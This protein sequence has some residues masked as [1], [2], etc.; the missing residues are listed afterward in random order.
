MAPRDGT[1]LK[2]ESGQTPPPPPPPKNDTWIPEWYQ[3]FYA[4]TP[5][6]R[7]AE[8][9]SPGSVPFSPVGQPTEPSYGISALGGGALG[10]G[11]FLEKQALNAGDAVTRFLTSQ[12]Q[13][14]WGKGLGNLAYDNVSRPTPLLPNGGALAAGLEMQEAGMDTGG[15]P[16]AS[17]GGQYKPNFEEYMASM[18]IGAGSGGGAARPDFS[19]YRAALTD[20][21]QQI[22]AQIQAMYNA[23]GE[24]AGANVG[25]IQDIYG[26]ASE[27][28]GDVYGSAIGNVG[29][30]YGSAQ[31]QAADQLARLG[32]EAA[33]PAVINP[34]ALSQAEAISQLEQGQAGG[35]AATERFGSAASGF[36]SQMAQ[37]AQQQ[38]TEMNAAILASLQNRLMDSLAAEQQGGGGGGGGGMS[39]RD[40]LALREAYNRDVLGQMPLEEREFALR[41]AQALADPVLSRSQRN[42]DLFLELTLPQDGQKPLMTDIE[43]EDYIRALES[44]GY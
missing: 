33:A 26:G 24:E 31:Q 13:A 18:G 43:A 20:Q 4:G 11:R 3:R 8:A 37:V 27:G 14:G 35:Q 28:I 29:D 25:R 19:A 38:G 9:Q 32:I 12:P 39:V 16:F 15:V 36:G 30:A 17:A 5:G 7:T 6:G 10:V 22:N 42:R 1:V 23:L 40:Q 34:M 44:R 2:I 21:A 41:E